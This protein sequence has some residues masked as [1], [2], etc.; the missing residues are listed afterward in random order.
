VA[1]LIPSS[2]ES[3]IHIN[4]YRTALEISENLPNDWAV[5]SNTN[6]SYG[7]H[8]KNRK[9]N[10]EIDFLVL[11]PF[12]IIHVIEYTQARADLNLNGEVIVV[13][14][15]GTKNKTLQ[16]TNNKDF[17]IELLKDSKNL[18]GS[19]KYFINS[20]LFVP[21]LLVKNPT[22]M[23]QKDNI[24]DGTSNY[25]IKDLTLKIINSNPD[26]KELIS[27][28]NLVKLFINQLDLVI[29]PSSFGES[30]QRYIKNF[31]PLG[32]AIL[33]IESS[34]QIIVID[35]VAGSGKTQLALIGMKISL[36]NGLKCALVSNTKVLPALIK[37]EL[38]VDFPAYTAFNFEYSTSLYD[39]IFVE[40]AHH[41]NNQVIQKIFTCLKPEGKMYLLMDQ[42]QN[43][44]DKF[45]IPKNSLI[46]HLDQ[47]YRV[48]IQI[49]EYLNS[50]PSFSTNII[51]IN[52]QE[53]ESIE[54]D[55][56]SK[57]LIEAAEKCAKYF[58]EFINKNPLLKENSALIFCGNQF[59]LN[60]LIKDSN[61]FKEAAENCMALD[62]E[63]KTSHSTLDTIRRFQGSSRHYIFC[64][65]FDE[66]LSSESSAKLF[67]SACTRARTK[68]FTFL[69]KTFTNKLINSF[70]NE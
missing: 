42:K 17:I 55:V 66:S 5:I 18:I 58:L 23:Y 61:I 60:Q 1:K 64:C 6:W 56:F 39:Y 68:C 53:G 62:S 32:H 47:T 63:Y 20:W 8:K 35:G 14:P 9:N 57:S 48:P 22:P 38:G 54:I 41:L 65:W 69:T 43:F 3:Y 37:R 10:G 21:N 27:I 2:P 30:S 44:D 12:G 52:T 70:T 24:V 33:R 31:E 4:E 19:Q 26:H 51:P 40:E 16:L 36:I 15:N 11:S 34:H 45:E 13:M 29:D 28:D 59:E 67:Y 49:C 7:K 25:P 46:I 50:F